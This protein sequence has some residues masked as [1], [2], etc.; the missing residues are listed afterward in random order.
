MLIVQLYLFKEICHYSNSRAPGEMFCLRYQKDIWLK[1]K[2][3]F[4]N[5]KKLSGGQFWHKL[6]QKPT[7]QAKF[8]LKLHQF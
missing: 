7:Q 6:H 3:F 8:Y 1:T 2:I 4:G 5:L